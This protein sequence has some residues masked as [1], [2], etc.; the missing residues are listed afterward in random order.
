MRS[1]GRLPGPVVPGRT[2]AAR[3]MPPPSRGRGDA[4]RPAV[5]IKRAWARH[6]GRA[7]SKRWNC[8]IHQPCRVIGTPICR[9]CACGEAEIPAP[10]VHRPQTMRT[11]LH[12]AGL[13]VE[14]AF[15]SRW[16]RH[17]RERG[18]SRHRAGA[19][20]GRSS[21]HS[22]GRSGGARSAGRRRRAAGP[23]PLREYRAHWVCSYSLHLACHA[24]GQTKFATAPWVPP[25][26][27]L[28]VRRIAPRPS[29]SRWG[30]LGWIA[31]MCWSPAAW[32]DISRLW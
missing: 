17:Q 4:A 1:C 11:T 20:P 12:H 26:A 29:Q 3:S 13:A 25:G 2:S 10:L 32:W 19:P 27:C 9:S 28:Y 18:P 22:E 14:R 5:P 15:A 24:S 31:K 23:A 21:A 7:S 6:A 16:S 30:G 8:A